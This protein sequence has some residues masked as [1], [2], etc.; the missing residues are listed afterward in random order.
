[1]IMKLPRGIRRRGKRTFQ[2][3]YRNAQGVLQEESFSGPTPEIAL[4]EA[5]RQLA[6]RMGDIAKGQPVTSKPNTVTFA[7]LCADVV[8]HYERNKLP[9]MPDIE[10]RYRLHLL[11]FF[12]M[13]RKASDIEETDFD[14]YILRRQQE[15]SAQ[16]NINREL[17]AAK[18]AF[19]LG[20]TKKRIFNIPTITMVEGDVVRQGFFER[21]QLEAVCR[22]LPAHLV[23]VARFGY[24]TGWRHQEV[25]TRCWK[26]VHG[27]GVR[28][29]PGETKNKKGRTFPMVQELKDI[30]DSVRPAGVVFPNTRVFLTAAGEEIGRFDKAWGTA[31]R[32]AG[33]PVRIVPICKA[34]RHADGTMKRDEKGQLILVPDLIKRG[35]NKGQVKS[36]CR[37]A[38]YFHDFRR[39]AYRN[40][41]RLGVPSSVA[42]AAVGWLDPMTAARY[43]ITSKGDLDTLAALYDAANLTT[44]MVKNSP[45]VVNSTKQSR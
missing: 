45:F 27:D 22:H 24:V 5:T 18:R 23:P 19:L 39:T 4:D 38:I 31:C 2:I 34:A 42:Q 17:E 40:L 41:L 11:P 44:K 14:R 32:K 33:L 30:I 43:D 13:T 29:E 12:G 21:E 25:M 10:A 28:L 6:I 36:I 7:E 16:G 20:K 37:S 9:S 1:M 3:R 8:N 26:H 35:K 15:G